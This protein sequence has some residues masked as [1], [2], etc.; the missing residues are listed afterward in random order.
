MDHRSDILVLEAR[1]SREGVSVARLCR[2]AEIAQ[3]T[4]HRWK[5]GES[6]PRPKIWEHV[7]AVAAELTPSTRAA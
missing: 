7:Q 6:V 2:R 1:L 4:W 3:S 5:T